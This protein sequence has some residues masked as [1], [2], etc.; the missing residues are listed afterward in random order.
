MTRYAAAVLWT[1]CIFAASSDAFSASHTGSVLQSFAMAILGHP[2]SDMTYELTQ[3]ATRKLAHL[4]E[5]GLLGWLWFRAVR[6]DEQGWTLRW[7][8][9]AVLIAIAVATTDEI[10][11]AFVPSRTG[12]PLD[13]IVDTCGAVV[14]QLVALHRRGV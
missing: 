10:H 7:S 13:V 2:L 14:A 4:T 3:L 1:I 8:V 5:Y 6:G 12:S 11:Q 9:T